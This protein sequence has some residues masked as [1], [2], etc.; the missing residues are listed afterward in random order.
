[1]KTKTQ[2]N[3]IIQSNLFKL[4]G[5]SIDI[6]EELNALC[7]CINEEQD[8]DWYIG[9]FEECDLSSLLIGAYWAMTDCHG[10]QSSDTYE[11]LCIIGTIYSPNMANGPEEDSS[12]QFAYEVICK[13]L[14][15]A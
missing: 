14:L 7:A 2:F 13:E 10:G 1:M 6:C 5:E 8:T 12:E 9:E 11:T 4:N 3:K 15:E